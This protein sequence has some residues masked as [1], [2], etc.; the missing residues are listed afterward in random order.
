MACKTKSDA[1]VWLTNAHADDFSA[2]RAG[3]LN[4]LC[5]A[6]EIDFKDQDTA[7]MIAALRTHSE[8]NIVPQDAKQCVAAVVASMRAKLA[9][10]RAQA[11]G[12]ESLR[13]LAESYANKKLIASAGGIKAVLAGMRS[14][15]TSEAVQEHGCH[16]L[17]SLSE[18]DDNRSLIE[19]DGGIEAV[20]AAMRARADDVAVF[21][22]GCAVL[23]DM[24]NRGDWTCKAIALAGGI[25]AIVV[26]MRTHAANVAAQRR[27][28]GSLRYISGGFDGNIESV[29][30]GNVSVIEAIVAS[31]RAHSAD[32]AVQEHGCAALDILSFLKCNRPRIASAGGIEAVHAAMHEHPTATNIAD[33]GK[34]VLDACA[35][36]TGSCTVQ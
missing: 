18:I 20:V 28:C 1:Q 12:C 30:T 32:A 3:E 33:R 2:L 23:W 10:A 27:G 7:T 26:G 34:R 29:V 6:L 36:Q 19:F 15:S 24:S 35:A 11:D 14:H 9:D 17:A 31:M 21:E 8:S 22:S 5:K 16:A 4:A 25:E 13:K